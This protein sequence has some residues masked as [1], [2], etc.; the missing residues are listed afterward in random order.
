[1]H[2]EKGKSLLEEC[3]QE[4]FLDEIP[5]GLAVE[6]NGGL[7]GDIPVPAQREAFMKEFILKRDLDSFVRN[8]VRR[9]S[10]LSKT[11]SWMK[12]CAAKVYSKMDRNVK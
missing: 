10:A 3:R 4:M 12:R 11:I 1:M 9:P 5:V 6:Q 8:Y 7:G 2:S